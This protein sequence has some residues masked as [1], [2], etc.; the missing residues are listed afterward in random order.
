MTRPEPAEHTLRLARLIREQAAAC[1]ELG[2]PLTAYLLDRLA[3]D[4]LADGPGAAVLAGHARSASACP[5]TD[6]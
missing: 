2:S 5:P 6:G 1:Q 4:V 3:D